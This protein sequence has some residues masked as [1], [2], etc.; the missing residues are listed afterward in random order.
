MSRWRM[1]AGGLALATLAL[2][3]GGC[4]LLYLA[5]G[6]GSQKALYR[7][8]K[9]QRVLVLVDVVRDEVAAPPYLSS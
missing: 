5:G 3:V 8:P 9:G 7:F 4:E 2:A 1:V 6:Q